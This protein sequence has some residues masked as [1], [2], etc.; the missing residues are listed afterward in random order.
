MVYL[1]CIVST[2]TEALDTFKYV[3]CRGLRYSTFWVSCITTVK[4]FNTILYHD[5]LNCNKE[6][7]YHHLYL[8]SFKNQL[9]A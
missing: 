6:M 8:K 1:P 2:A 9:K 7:I 4:L 3:T 5:T